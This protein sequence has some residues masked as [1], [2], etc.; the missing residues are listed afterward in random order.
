[1]MEIGEE[2]LDREKE[3]REEGDGLR[4]LKMKPGMVGE[5]DDSMIVWVT[6]WKIGDIGM[7][8]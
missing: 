4:I 3:W 6:R 7:K 5:E 1:M 8:D 2:G